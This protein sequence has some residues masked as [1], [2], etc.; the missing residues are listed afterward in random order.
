MHE[1]ALPAR[2][3]RRRQHEM[4][5]VRCVL[6]L[7]RWATN[8]WQSIGA[9][10]PPGIIW[11]DLLDPS[12]DERQFVESRLNIRVPTEDALSEI[13]ASSRLISDHDRRI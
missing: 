5:G 9:E 3:C 10:L 6:N 8:D 4:H 2:A 7:Y 13:E 11:I 1:T 12:A